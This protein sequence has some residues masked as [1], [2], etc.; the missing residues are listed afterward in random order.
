MHY[1]AACEV[2]MTGTFSTRLDKSTGASSFVQPQ[3]A[4]VV[5]DCY[6]NNWYDV[7]QSLL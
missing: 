7:A 2:V 3:S 6:W 4:L 1:A 5:E